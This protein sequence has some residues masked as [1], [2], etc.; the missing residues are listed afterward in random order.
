MKIECKLMKVGN[1]LCAVIPM[2]IL[3]AMGK[4]QG[5]K[6]KLEIKVEEEK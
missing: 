3:K 5:D 2:A 1:S 4:Q 6:I